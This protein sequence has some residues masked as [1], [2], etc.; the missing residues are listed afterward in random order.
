MDK[1]ND[2]GDREE[3]MN[4]RIIWEVL[5]IIF[6]NWLDVLYEEEERIKVV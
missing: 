2:G 3:K 4:L 6:I 5:F 1:G